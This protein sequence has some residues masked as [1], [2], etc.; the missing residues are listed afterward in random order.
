MIDL[1]ILIVGGGIAGAS[2]GAEVAARRRTLIIEAEEHCGVTAQVEP[3]APAPGGQVLL[4]CAPE[5]VERLGSK[6]L[7][8]IGIVG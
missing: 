7:Q 2:V 4:A 5:N 3:P 6:G 1:D 8:Q